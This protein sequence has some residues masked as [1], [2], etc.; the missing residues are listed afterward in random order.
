[1]HKYF[2][3]IIGYFLMSSCSN[4]EVS[5][6]V[7]DVNTENVSTETQ[8]K[9]NDISFYENKTLHIYLGSLQ[10]L[11]E[12]QKKEIY[13]FGQH[14]DG[15]NSFDVIWVLNKPYIERQL[16]PNLQ[17]GYDNSEASFVN[18]KFASFIFQLP[19]KNIED[20][21][22]DDPYQF[23]CNVDVFLLNKKRELINLGN[24][25]VKTWEDYIQL[26]YKVIFKEIG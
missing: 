22:L 17:D 2:I 5:P 12:N 11:N 3:Y 9:K 10:S 26:Q 8:N 25:E 18:E 20:I 15:I 7:F 19:L 16:E 24:F 6:K 13:K 21:L 14:I 23:P 1:M 4:Q